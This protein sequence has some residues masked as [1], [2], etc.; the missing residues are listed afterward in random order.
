[1]NS[2][3]SG[4]D[5]ARCVFI[6]VKENHIKY[7]KRWLRN[8]AKGR[9]SDHEMYEISVPFVVYGKLWGK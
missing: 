4:C 2:K 7:V 6:N 1:M 9:K 3:E 8:D 5:T